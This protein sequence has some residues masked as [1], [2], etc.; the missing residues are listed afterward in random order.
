[1]ADIQL[2][3]GFTPVTESLPTNDRPVLAI[4]RS[5]YITA[6]FEVITARYQPQHRPR[7]PWQDISGDAVTETGEDVLG[8]RTADEWLSP[9]A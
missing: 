2:P 4:R 5:G 6:K 3:T 8:W 7:A 1:M 9:A